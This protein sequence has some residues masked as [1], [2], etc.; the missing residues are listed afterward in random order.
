MKYIQGD[1]INSCIFCDVLSPPNDDETLIVFRGNLVF[2]ILNLYPY[3]S[4]HLMVVPY[5]HVSTLAM[6]DYSTRTELMEVT[7]QATQ[8]LSQVYKP[9]GFNLGINIGQI[10]G[11]GIQDHIHLHVVPRWSGDTNFMSSVGETRVLPEAIQITYSR[12]KE[13]WKVF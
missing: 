8:V 10:A 6:L 7:T 12:I 5:M 3:T 11:A 4:G 2:V 13:A 1:K 9:E